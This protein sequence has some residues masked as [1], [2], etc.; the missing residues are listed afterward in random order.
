ME[1]DRQVQ[2]LLASPAPIG[3]VF[4]QFGPQAEPELELKGGSIGN[5]V[6]APD[7]GISFQVGD[8]DRRALHPMW[9]SSEKHNVY[10]LRLKMPEQEPETQSLTIRAFG[11]EFG[12]GEP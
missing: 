8:L 9:W 3:S 4:L 5:M 1:G 6:L 12:G 11:L 10:L 7:G 2:L